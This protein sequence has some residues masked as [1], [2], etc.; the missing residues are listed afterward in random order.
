VRTTWNRIQLYRRHIPNFLQQPK[1]HYVVILLVITDLI[2]VLIDLVL[3]MFRTKVLQ[4]NHLAQLSSSCLINA[5]ST[6]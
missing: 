6:Y 3:A 4:S 1:F 2:I 5:E